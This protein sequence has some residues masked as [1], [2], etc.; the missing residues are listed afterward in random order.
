MSY[1]DRS[2]RLLDVKLS[3]PLNTERLGNVVNQEALR[4]PQDR[5]ECFGRNRDRRIGASGEP[6]IRCPAARDPA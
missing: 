6:I 2:S 4:Q 3:K 1:L 5:E